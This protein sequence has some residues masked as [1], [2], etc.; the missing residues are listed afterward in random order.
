MDY[1]SLSQAM[2][3][4]VYHESG[5]KAGAWTE[6]ISAHQ[7]DSRVEVGVLASQQATEPESLSLGGFLAVLG[8]DQKPSM[9]PG[10]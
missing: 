1:D 10:T 6:A 8:E 7:T 5:T 2:T 4:R 9:L 3:L